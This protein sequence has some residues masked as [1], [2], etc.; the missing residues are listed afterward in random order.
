MFCKNCGKEIPDKAKFC[1]NCGFKVDKDNSTTD[2][3]NEALSNPVSNNE[4]EIVSDSTELEKSSFEDG[5][6]S[7]KPSRIKADP[8]GDGKDKAAENPVGE[9]K[10]RIR[11]DPFGEKEDNVS[12]GPFSD[13]KTSKRSN[14]KGKRKFSKKKLLAIGIIVIIFLIV[15]SSVLNS[16]SDSYDDTSSYYGSSSYS[17]SRGYDINYDKVYKIG[18]DL[19]AGEYYIKATSY[20]MYVE[21]ASD[22]SGDIE[23]IVGNLN[24]QGGIYVTVHNGEYLKIVDGKLYELKNMPDVDKKNG[25]LTEGQ[26]KV[27]TDIPAGVYTIEPINGWGYFELTSDSRH[28]LFNII[29]N[30]NFEETTTVTLSD[31]Q[32]IELTNA[33]L[34]L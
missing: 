33:K 25:Y 17:S 23:S 31:G 34:K 7:E 3:K 2:G 5:P 30:D 20:S 4:N 16:G 1:S 28:D 21:I 13:K 8:F 14:S 11:V 9:Q 10:S 26:Y 15:I 19:P 24:T 12:D 32:Y 6:F 18:T 27:G 29:T 22:N